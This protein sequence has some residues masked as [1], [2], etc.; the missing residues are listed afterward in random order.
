SEDSRARLV[1]IENRGG[2]PD[3]AYPYESP[4]LQFDPPNWSPKSPID[5]V[6]IAYARRFRTDFFATM[7]FWRE[8]F[9]EFVT[10]RT[11]STVL[12]SPRTDIGLYEFEV[13]RTVRGPKR[14][15]FE[16]GA[17]RPVWKESVFWSVRPPS[18]N[19]DSAALRSS[20]AA[21]G[22]KD[23]ACAS[24]KRAEADHAVVHRAMT[25]CAYHSAFRLGK[26]AVF[27]W[28]NDVLAGVA[29]I[30]AEALKVLKISA[31]PTKR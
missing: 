9:M 7:D 12:L 29:E 15:R 21:C 11:L 31:P 17:L 8:G 6:E 25:N 1:Y 28:R 27:Y 20:L 4:A 5:R 10:S 13:V 19:E 2:G 22:A 23:L 16:F 30:P 3:V 18:A 14:R 24:S 26:P